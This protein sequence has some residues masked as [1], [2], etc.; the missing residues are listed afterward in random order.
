MAEQLDRIPVVRVSGTGRNVGKTTLVTHLISWL[1]ARGYRVSAV[2]RTHHSVPLDRAGSDTDQMAEAGANR[3]AFVGPDGVVE[4]SGPAPL[5]EVVAR[6][7]A[8]ADVVVVEGNRDESLGV[9]LHLMGAPPAQ[10]AMRA[11]DGK[12]E[13]SVSADDL[14]EIG[15]FIEQALLV[16]LP[17]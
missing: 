11:G 9:Q 2:K 12:F 16:P 5:E 15:E 14:A 13:R 17:T 1:S 8:D 7:S 6:L 3:V 4:R 10:V